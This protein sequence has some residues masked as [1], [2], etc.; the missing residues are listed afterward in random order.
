MKPLFKKAI[1]TENK[2]YRPISHLPV[3][4]KVIEKLIHNQMQDYLQRN[5][6][7]YSYQSG[8]TANHP[9]DT[10]LS[11]VC[12]MIHVCLTDM[13]LNSAENGKHMGMILIELN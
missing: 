6:Q 4:L 9:S 11:H 2:K 1:K 10:C 13:I 3:I 8:F 5:E 7:L 12:L